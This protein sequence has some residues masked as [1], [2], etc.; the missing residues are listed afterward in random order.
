MT[1]WLA[2]LMGVLF[3]WLAVKI[4]FYEMWVLFFNTLISIYVS[5][6]LTPVLA[7]LAPVPEGSAGYQIALCMIVLAGGSFAL[8]QGLAYVFLTGQYRIPFPRVFDIVLSGV[9]GFG[10]GFLILS[11]L[12]LALATT[13]L[14]AHKIVGDLGAGQ[15]AQRANLLYLARCCDVVHA[16]ARFDTAD[17]TTQA[18]LQRLMELPQVLPHPSQKSPEVN[19]PPT[20]QPPKETTAR[21]GRRLPDYDMQ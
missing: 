13:P 7:E 5:I 10:T 18:A 14:A 3:V 1:F 17:N 2:I 15:Q 16:F 12:A 9:V 19:E 20:P 4:R 6:F 11:F 8:L 21:K